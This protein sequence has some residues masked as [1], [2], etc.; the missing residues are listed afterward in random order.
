M[1]FMMTKVNIFLVVNLTYTVFILLVGTRS[2][3]KIIFHCLIYHVYVIIVNMK[4]KILT[5]P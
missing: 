4:F 1:F 5:K 2:K 3:F